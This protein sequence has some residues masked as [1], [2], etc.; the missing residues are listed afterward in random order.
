MPAGTGDVTRTGRPCHRIS[1]ARMGARAV[2]SLRAP[3]RITAIVPEPPGFVL[4]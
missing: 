1:Q 2:P 4:P 3:L